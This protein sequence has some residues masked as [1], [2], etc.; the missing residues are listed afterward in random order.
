MSQPESAIALVCLS[1]KYQHTLRGT[2]NATN[3]PLTNLLE[4]AWEAIAQT[5]DIVKAAQQQKRL[6]PN[7]W[8]NRCWSKKGYSYIL[9][10]AEHVQRLQ[11]SHRTIQRQPKV[12]GSG[13]SI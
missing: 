2:T 5:P 7:I 4:K 1:L 13:S 6:K 10:K 9:T 8:W 12:S 11:G 3:Q